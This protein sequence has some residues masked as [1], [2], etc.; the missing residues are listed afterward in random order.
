MSVELRNMGKSPCAD[1]TR[2]RAAACFFFRA[3]ED[4]RSATVCCVAFTAS[5]ALAKEVNRCDACANAAIAPIPGDDGFAS[6]SF[7][8]DSCAEQK[9]KDLTWDM[10][11]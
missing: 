4:C 7:S 1:T 8:A 10:G 5:L 2:M 9:S 3:P 11:L 6:S